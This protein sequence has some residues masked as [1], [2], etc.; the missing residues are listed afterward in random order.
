MLG[1]GI[2]EVQN[3]NLLCACFLKKNWASAFYQFILLSWSCY[4][5]QESDVMQSSRRI[6]NLR[7]KEKGGGKV[8]RGMRLNNVVKT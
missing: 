5:Q 7:I 6:L 1:N 3:S 8:N 2:E 4:V